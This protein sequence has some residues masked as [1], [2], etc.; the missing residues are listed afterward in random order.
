M[1]LLL[2]WIHSRYVCFRTLWV[3]SH[4]TIRYSLV[5]SRDRIASA[6][7]GSLW[8]Y[9]S[10]LSRVL[11]F[12]PAL[13]SRWSNCRL[14]LV[15]LWTHHYMFLMLLIKQSCVEVINVAERIN[16]GLLLRLYLAHL[17]LNILTT[18]AHQV[19]KRSPLWILIRK[20]N[21]CWLKSSFT[22]LVL[23][24]RHS[25]SVCLLLLLLFKLSELVP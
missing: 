18:R 20:F 21:G 4:H 6:G 1:H 15:S 11:P 13:L 17:L 16:F 3:P 12:L 14:V 5:G 10:R 9:S 7:I 19:R 8:S 25:K 23:L 22:E 2:R 24:F